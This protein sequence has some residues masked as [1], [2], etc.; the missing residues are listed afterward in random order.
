[1][2]VKPGVLMVTGAYFPE[3][4]G[5]GLQAR[6]VVRALSDRVAFSV[7]TTSSD[8]SLPR[9]SEEEGIPIRRVF[10]NPRSRAS[11]LKAAVALALLLR[12]LG[13]QVRHGQ[14]PRFLA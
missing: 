2:R 12:W 13:R 4:S 10:V 11:Q 5:G 14:S 7:L 6:A 8:P 9:R 1:M 3:L